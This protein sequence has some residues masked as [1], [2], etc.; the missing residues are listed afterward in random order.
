VQLEYLLGLDVHSP[1]G[2]LRLRRETGADEVFRFALFAGS[3]P[4]LAL[5]PE[6]V[7]AQVLL[8]QFLAQQAGYSAQYPDALLA[9]IERDGTPAGR[10]AVAEVPG[11][12]HIVDIAIA[13]A[14]RGK[15]LGTAVLRALHKGTPLR[16]H[17]STSNPAAMRLYARLGFVMIA[18]NETALEMR[19]G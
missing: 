15:G 12:L 5:L 13:G 10:L 8:Q 1:L 16:L 11:A 4:D 19:W 3:R 18:E 6:P 17:V 2:L 7:R 9:I 14:L